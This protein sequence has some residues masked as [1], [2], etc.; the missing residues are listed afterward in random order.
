MEIRACPYQRFPR[1]PL[2]L[3]RPH[4]PLYKNIGSGAGGGGDFL[5]GER[6]LPCKIWLWFQEVSWPVL[7]KKSSLPL[8]GS[9]GRCVFQKWLQWHIP[10]HM[11]SSH[12]DADNPEVGSL[13][14]PLEFGW[15]CN[16]SRSDA[17]SLLRL[18]HKGDTPP[19]GLSGILALG[20]QPPCWEERNH[21][22]SPH[23]SKCSGWKSHQVPAD[24]ENQLLDNE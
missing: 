11:L 12:C 23:V 13:F 10:S 1:R 24:N 5:R 6:Y 18:G 8:F 16:S 20:T 14:P 22:E 7:S 19:T 2:I 21:I 3:S 9:Y 17:M 4:T 15:T